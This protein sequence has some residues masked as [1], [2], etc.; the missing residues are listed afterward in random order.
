MKIVICGLTI[1]S[2]WGNGHATTYRALVRE[3][4][5]RGHQVLFLEQDVPWYAA[6]RDLP[7][8]PYGQT[9]LYRDVPDLKN[10]FEHPIR[11]ADLVM[12]G[13]YVPNGIAVGEWVNA[14][15]RG[16]TAFYDIDTPVTME[17]LQKNECEY[18]SV[19]TVP[20][21]GMYLSFAGGRILDLL[22]ERFGA[23]RALPLYCSVDTH[24]YFPSSEPARYDLGYMGTYSDDRQPVLDR[25]LLQ[26]AS[27]W[28]EGR[29]AVAG[30]QFPDSIRWPGNVKRI[31]HLPPGV[32]RRFYTSQ[33]YT[34]NVTRAAMVSNGYS[35]SVRLFEAA[36]CGTPI[37]SDY[38]E[39]LES[40]FTPGE[41]ILISRSAEETLSFLR[42]LP[43]QKRMTIGRR[44]RERAIAEHSAATRAAQLEEYVLEFLS[45]PA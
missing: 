11:E 33:R 43:E 23:Q 15:A 42:E 35:P 41:E 31:D 22:E 2:S 27:R 24:L 14:I 10:R 6:N 40:F 44:A 39:G 45:I 30:P 25:L 4:T 17:K 20:R 5:N 13:S 7:S 26:A 21:Y 3:L 34:L 9:K 38:W 1:T 8:P 19:D 18:L 12:V 16:I 28:P 36:A 32:H 29:F 37:I